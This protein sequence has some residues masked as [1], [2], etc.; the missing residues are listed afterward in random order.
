[1]DIT[2]NESRTDYLNGKRMRFIDVDGLEKEGI[3]HTDG[4]DCLS[5][6]IKY[7]EWCD[8][9][10]IIVNKIYTDEIEITGISHTTNEEIVYNC[11]LDGVKYQY[12]LFEPGCNRK[13]YIMVTESNKNANFS[14]IL[15]DKIYLAVEKFKTIKNK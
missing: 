14:Q 9:P 12:H 3:A 13:D 6:M 15:E 10:F 8:L 5:I 1:M 11:K 2:F 7:G 4:K